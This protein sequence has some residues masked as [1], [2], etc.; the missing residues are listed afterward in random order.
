LRMA[1]YKSDYYYYYYFFT[2]GTYNP[3]GDKKLRSKYK[4][5]YDHQSVQ[6]VASKL[7]CKRTAL[8]RCI[9]IIILQ[10]YRAYTGRQ[11]DHDRLNDRQMR[12]YVHGSAA[13]LF[14][15]SNSI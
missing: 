6:S 12:G 5:G 4:I 3:E 11:T 14:Q 8:K 1:L 7:S 15:I 13:M 2:L 9:I 10:R